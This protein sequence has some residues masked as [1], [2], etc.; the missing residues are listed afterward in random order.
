MGLKYSIVIPTLNEEYFLEKNL[1]RLKS[2]DRNLEIIVA[3]GGSSDNTIGV[4]RRFGVQTINSLSG[5]GRQLNAGAT[6]ASGDILIF[7][8]ADTFLP[9]NAFKLSDE[10]F[11]A[12]ENKICRF[13]LGFDF[14]HKLL[15]LYSAFS[16][17]DTKFTGF[18]DAAIIIRKTLFEELNGFTYGSIFEDTDF[19]NRASKITKIKIINQSVISSA[20][21][22]I[23]DGVI[24]RQLHNAFLFAGYILNINE[25]FLS[26]MYDQQLNKMKTNSILIFVRNPKIGEVKTRLA[27]TTSEKFA[28]G[29]YK[30]CAE[31]IIRKIKKIPQLNQ[32]IFYSSKEDKDDVIKWLG[33]N[34]FFS[35]QEGND[36]GSRM[37][38]AFEK[39]F[40]TGTQKVII[41]GSDIPDLSA[42]IINKAFAYLDGSD[43]VIGSSK[44]GGF[45]LLGM[46]KMYAELFEGIEY[47]TA[48]VFSETLSR[49]K[50]LKLSCKLLPELQDID[51]EE[52]LIRWLNGSYEN[53]IKKKIKLAY[54]TI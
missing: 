23:K 53:N 11:Q 19:L 46:K 34:Y 40:S 2:I 38:S 27:K 13:L 9:D 21:R 49:I 3:D 39:V 25:N 35:A 30:S 41:I 17:F 45:Y 51:T 28:L 33:S 42:E 50:E 14:N 48:K 36:L 18:G 8:H 43:V 47:S 6:A 32:F 37:K 52:D 29:F 15:D 44:D 1:K 26:R 20:R 12:K 10:F 4:C 31:N 7:L 22:F 16:K 54:E 24:R 5:R